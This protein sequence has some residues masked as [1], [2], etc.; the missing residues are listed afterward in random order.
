[1]AI[2]NSLRQLVIIGAMVG[3]LLTLG[4]VLGVPPALAAPCDAPVVNKVACENTQAGTPN[5][6]VDSPDDTIVGF[7]TDI[8]ATPG[9]TVT[10]KVKTTATSYNVDIFRLG[11][12]GGVGARQVGTAS[13]T[14]AQTQPTC[15]HVAA[16]GL[17]DCGNWAPSFTWTVPSTA[18]SGIYYAVLHRNDNGGE[19]EVV[20]VVRDDSSMSKV[21]FQTSDSTW[22]AY[23]TY[24]DQDP[25][26]GNSLYTGTGPGP[27]G[28]AWKVS[29]NRPIQGSGDEN[30]IF[31]AEYPMLRFLEANGYDLSYTTDTDTARR[32]NLLTN[33]KVFMA[34]GHDEYWSK[35]QRN[36]VEAAR[37][38][39]VNLA[40]LTGN[41]VFWK[42]R[43][44]NSTDASATPLRTLVC[45]KETKGAVDPSATEW[46]GTWRDP[47]N[48]PPKDGGKPENS[49]LG[50]IFMVNGR[51]DD[52]MQVPATYGKM[53]LWRNTSLASMAAG[54][55]YTFRPG[56]LGYEWNSVEDN[57]A[58]PAGVAQM[59]RTT[60]NITD[61]PYVL[62]NYGDVYG[63]GTKTHALTMYRAASGALVF[64][65]G[66]VQWAWGVD[67]DHVF[68]TGTPTSDVRIK[69][70]TVNF[71][72]D[73]GV[74]PTTLQAGLVAT[75]ASTDTAAPTVA[76]TSA[77]AA[78]VGAPYTF[79]GTVSDSGGQVAGVE[80]SADGGTTWHPAAWTAGATTWTYTFTP[81]ASGQLALRARAT[82][83]SANLS[84]PVSGTAAAGARQ[85]PCSIWTD[86]TTPGTPDTAD[87]TPVEVGVKWRATTNG[88]V[89]G[90]RF[91]KGVGNT[92]THTGSLWSTSGQRLATGTFT[93]ETA[94]GWQTLQFPT[95]VAVTAN[96]TYI[97]S[98]FASAGHYASDGGYFTGKG[99][100]LEPLTALASGVDGPN[101]VYRVSTSGFPNSSFADANYWVD[102]VWADTAGAD[103]RA[104]LVTATSPVNGSSS[105]ALNA[106][107]SVTFDEPME[108]ASVQ[109]TMT[110]PAGA[111]AGTGALSADGLTATFTPAQPLTAG[112]QYTTSLTATDVAGN[113]VAASVPVNF[114]TASSRPATCPCTVWDE[115]T[116]PALVDVDDGA[117]VEVGTKVRFDRPGQVVGVRFYKGMA[118]S[119]T[120]TGSLWS[121]TGARLATGT[122]S[123]ESSTGWQMLTFAA[124]VD[125]QAATTYVVS[126]YAPNGRYSADS[127]YFN[128]KGADYQFLHALASGVDGGNGV[129]RY[130]SGGG[131]P[132]SAFNGGN[133]WVDPIFQLPANADVMPPTLTAQTPTPNATGV[134]LPAAVTATFSEPVSLTGAQFTVADPGGAML[135][136]ALT[137]SA[138]QKTVTWTPSAP[139]AAGTAYAVSA[140][141]LDTAGN[142]MANAAT[143][144]FTTTATPT[145]PCSLFSTATLPTTI[146]ANDSGAYEM[147]VRFAPA[148]N[149]AITGVKFY[150]GAANT[151]THTGTLW[152][153]SGQ[154]LATGTF[155]GETV[156][157]WQTL[158]FATPV[159]VTAGTI[160]VAS[161]TNTTGHYSVD[162]GYFQRTAVTN[163]LL[164]AP[165]AGNGVFKVGTGFPTSTFQ[166][167]NYWV[168][169]LYGVNTDNAPPAVT[170]RTPAPAATGVAVN[171][172][173]TVTFDEPVVDSTV[174]LSVA[175]PNTAKLLGA[176][177]LSADKKTAT[178]T[179]S[180]PL[181]GSTAYTVS[182][183]AAD[184]SGNAPAAPM[185]WSFTTAA[186]Q[187]PCSLYS[188]A[189]VPTTVDSNDPGAYE[190]GVRFTPTVN[191]TVTAVKFYKAATNTGTHTG[192]LWS[193]TGQQLATGTFTNETASGWQTLTFATPVAVTAGTTYVASYTTSGGHYSADTGY[194]EQGAVTTPPLGAPA[195]GNGVY[196]PGMG[197]P[198]S[199][200]RGS[201]Y[202]VDV[203]FAPGP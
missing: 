85:C 158:T 151:G 93:N 2:G 115:L 117:A 144:S 139:Y 10:F 89:R 55:T 146:D 16:V 104:P 1:M 100:S 87:N 113:A 15:N 123:G 135:A 101:G 68:D 14:T 8:S 38:A 61:G 202:W 129:Y 161:Y 203:V 148:T 138:D 29:Y 65:A 133:Y 57:G 40:F 120:H 22:Q 136:G 194:F 125:V 188:A 49:L 36:N 84:A 116:T 37:N 77:P 70:A 83:D 107:V 18:V 21:V 172:P 26:N 185:T 162:T 112:T 32:G 19:N 199:S 66:T 165:A 5:W 51:R 166:G 173:V 128:G 193:S 11:W 183:S 63:T 181:A 109:F 152:S 170:A 154:Q 122:F 103:T 28:S 163:P 96:T 177:T 64:G 167:G 178:W 155:G 71:L 184:A 52:S 186:G 73:M 42:T 44:E 7:T 9:S 197:F 127:A 102:V 95:S 76:I 182:V 124:P 4:A 169:V 150:K 137:L 171:A 43:W 147:G 153:G 72:A 34:V 48:S 111:V 118:N 192:T 59:S 134:A 17:V 200:F 78:T 31:N 143:W 94:T 13:R 67:D 108:P 97:A 175:D 159:N 174:Q 168:D 106:P 142:P 126:Y 46:T 45:Y 24:D 145:C 179:P 6:M 141:V 98:Y 58:Q 92:G 54:T 88:F 105:V 149:G 41:E 50:N 39:G 196:S 25:V 90:V 160:Y 187:C 130:G 114:K 12:Y 33:H 131:F 69:Q 81:S 60:V 110:S 56:T 190:M 132:T 53:R 119:G 30:F 121:A 86:A 80:V 27:Q 180:A 198:T 201:N 176:V 82:D 157:G 189:T 99:A 195:A 191:G 62:Q 140:K 79:S 75:T 35:E 3:F 74:Q 91:Y 23:N 20:F 164:S 156:S 47:R